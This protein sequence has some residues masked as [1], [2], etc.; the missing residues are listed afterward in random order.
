M[1]DIDRR[2]GIELFLISVLGLFL[3]MACI[4]WLP[5]QV[6][7]LSY[8]TNF[9]LLASFLGLGIGYML[10]NKKRN[11][12][13]S[14][15]FLFAALIGIASF[16]GRS[17]IEVTHG[18]SVY[19]WQ[20]IIEPLARIDLKWILS[21]FFMMITLLFIP[22]GQ[23]TGRLFD[24]L[25]P[26]KAY[27]LNIFGNIFGI[28]F[29]AVLSYNLV[30]PIWIFAAF[31][32]C[33]LYFVYTGSSRFFFTLTA[34]IFA[35]VMI[36]IYAMDRG[37]FW[38]PYYKIE[39]SHLP[40]QKNTD[41]GFLLTVNNDYHQMALNLSSV[42]TANNDANSQWADLYEL[43]FRLKKNVHNALIVGAGT[44]NDVA[45]ALRV[46][47]DH[48]DAVDIDPLILHIGK[49][50]H[51]EH[52]YDSGKVSV[53]NDDARSFF[54]KTD[55]KYDVIV[56]GFLDSHQL[57]SS[58]SEIR[59]DTYVYT[60]QSLREA[61]SLL[62]PDGIIALTFCVTK[63]W[64]GIRLRDMMKEATGEMPLMLDSGEVPNGFTYVYGFKGSVPEPY[65]IIS[66]DMF[67]SAQVSV[68]TD[69][70]PFFYLRHKTIPA[71]YLIVLA[72]IF[73]F[74]LILVFATGAKEVV[75]LFH[76]FFFFLGAGF[77]LFE[78]QSI[79]RMSLLFGSTWIVNS[80]VFIAIFA[81]VLCANYF[82]GKVN[83]KN[84]VPFYI[85]LFVSLLINY[86]FPLQL[87]L[88]YPLMIKCV[89]AGVLIG[90]PIFFSGVIFVTAFRQTPSRSA[91][92]GSNLIG[93]MLG[94]VME[95]SSM[96]FGIKSL[97]IIVALF[98]LFTFL[99]RKINKSA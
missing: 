40:D 74:S 49:R 72:F 41:A 60:V 62:K 52:P 68:P 97:I 34:V 53:Y 86:L 27:T 29:F 78:T 38:S 33:Y 10:T 58:M 75:R 45:A 7:V 31:M 77:L 35:V 94:G 80:A 44:G 17:N 43:P 6:K 1:K 32:I 42:K 3:E 82:V 50:H 95:Y 54:K 64:I 28:I 37:T 48:I 8:Y 36:W 5:S 89:G 11:W 39:V 83:I 55:K 19:F 98:Y 61:Q 57:F 59:L 63:D 21:I 24:R 22:L 2:E 92:M 71:D 56:F 76:P 85:C 14:F 73:V 66:P 99:T 65:G 26:L 90:L 47:V 81:T 96:L 4:R 46:G 84:I 91:A 67:G 79:T 51:P 88:S 69:Q 13:F 12:L 23:Q 9:V 15:P 20:T 93:A 70:W 16:L 25:A 87:I 18:T 30:P